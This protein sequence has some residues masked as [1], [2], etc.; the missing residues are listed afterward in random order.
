[1]KLL[2]L[3]G[4]PNCPKGNDELFF[5]LIK[6]QYFFL[7]FGASVRIWSG[8]IIFRYIYTYVKF[9]NL[10]ATFIFV[11]AILH[12]TIKLH[13]WSKFPLS[14]LNTSNVLLKYSQGNTSV[15]F[16]SFGLFLRICN[17][18]FLNLVT[19]YCQI[20]PGR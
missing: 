15:Q 10:V 6:S 13:N 7:D 9:I 8:L 12:W 16:R 1:M 17:I 18:Y 20:K 11:K 5:V 2:N 14:C 19:R 3:R 4:Q